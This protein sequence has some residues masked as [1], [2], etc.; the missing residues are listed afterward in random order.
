MKIQKTLLQVLIT[1]PEAPDQPARDFSI[2]AHLAAIRVFGSKT[3]RRFNEVR[4]Q[5]FPACSRIENITRLLAHEWENF[6][7]EFSSVFNSDTPV[8]RKLR[9]AVGTILSFILKCTPIKGHFRTMEIEEVLSKK[10]IHAWGLGLQQDADLLLVFESD[11]QLIGNPSSLDSIY[12]LMGA[13]SQPPTIAFL[14]TPF[15]ES[16][17]DVVSVKVSNNSELRAITPGRSNTAC[18][19]ILN[20]PAIR[21]ICSW[22][23][24]IIPRLRADWLINKFLKDNNTLVLWV[25]EEIVANT[26]LLRGGIS[27][28]RT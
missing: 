1:H 20:K 24:P 26:S 7:F 9:R 13:D 25:S 19:Y 17:V 4:E 3:P 5:E 27:S 23:E 15:S 22:S 10:H 8:A 14:S 2:Y 12:S 16:Q 21:E 18:C 6:V 11:A 28:V